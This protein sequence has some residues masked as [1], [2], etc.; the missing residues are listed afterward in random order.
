VGT[1]SGASA[2][3]VS[4]MNPIETDKA[5]GFADDCTI[6]TLM[7]Y[8]SLKRLHEVLNQFG[9]FSGLKC[10]ME[11]TFIMQIGRVTPIERRVEQLGFKVANGLKLLGVTITNHVEDFLDNFNGVII[12]IRNIANYWER[13]NLSLMGRIR[14]CKTMLVLQVNYLGSF[15]M[16]SDAQLVE[17]QSV[18]DKFCMGRTQCAKNK[19]YLPPDKGGLGLIN[20]QEFLTAQQA[21]WVIKAARNIKDNW[22]VDMRHL[23]NGNIWGATPLNAIPELNPV[24]YWLMT[25]YCKVK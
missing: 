15:V 3:G 19:V 13:F 10:N 5:D 24:C 6:T 2:R 7:E 23:C 8:D 1:L 12:K 18:L 4:G 20:I 21:G 11:K 16:P 17:I 22:S 14:I 9:V 25:S